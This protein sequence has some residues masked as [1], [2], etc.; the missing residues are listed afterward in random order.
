MFISSVFSITPGIGRAL[1][2]TVFVTAAGSQASAM[3]GQFSAKAGNTVVTSVVSGQARGFS[4]SETLALLQRGVERGLK[5]VQDRHVVTSLHLQWTLHDYGHPGRPLVD[6]YVPAHDGRGA[7][8][9]SD[10]VAASAAPAAAFVQAISDLTERA[11]AA[12]PA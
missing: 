12:D 10:S 4:A 6:V 11:L 8:H 5:H 7:R 2:A 3:T 9:A 1:L